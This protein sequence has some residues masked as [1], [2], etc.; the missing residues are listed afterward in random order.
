MDGLRR[1]VV[2][3]VFLSFLPMELFAGPTPT[4]NERAQEAA[5]RKKRKE[6]AAEIRYDESPYLS[7]A[8]DTGGAYRFNAKGEPVVPPHPRKPKKKKHGKKAVPA[9]PVEKKEAAPAASDG[10]KKK[11]QPTEGFSIEG[12]NS[13]PSRGGAPGAPQP[14][15]GKPPD[16]ATGPADPDSSN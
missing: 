12:Q 10:S 6:H 8:P 15:S 5:E 9:K 1:I 14:P 11:L 16:A 7:P 2:A 13:Q 3:A 4:A